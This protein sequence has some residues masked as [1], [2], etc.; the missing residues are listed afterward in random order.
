MTPFAVSK[1]KVSV[2]YQWKPEMRHLGV[3]AGL[4]RTDQSRM[5]QSMTDVTLEKREE[6]GRQSRALSLL[7]RRASSMCGRKN[8]VREISTPNTPGEKQSRFMGSIGAIAGFFTRKRFS[9]SQPKRSDEEVA[10]SHDQ[11]TSVFQTGTK[12]DASENEPKPNADKVVTN[13]PSIERRAITAPPSRPLLVTASEQHLGTA[14]TAMVQ[15]RRTISAIVP[16][17]TITETARATEAG[18]PLI[19]ATKLGDPNLPADI[20]AALAAMVRGTHAPSKSLEC[21]FVIPTKRTG[22][23]SIPRSC[24]PMTENEVQNDGTFTTKVDAEAN[25]GTKRR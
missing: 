4:R 5:S 20:P 18:G 13:V 14:K 22:Q 1:K 12:R 3:T 11:P 17:A 19:A 7:L 21:S 6:P 10:H 8:K 23:A 15:P 24:P 9:E 16:T 2:D 25:G